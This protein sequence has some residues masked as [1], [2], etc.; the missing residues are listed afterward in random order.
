M[1]P[2]LSV[3]IAHDLFSKVRSKA[4]AQGRPLSWVVSD[5]LAAGLLALNRKPRARKAVAK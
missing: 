5:L 3:T 4:E 1:K 2:T